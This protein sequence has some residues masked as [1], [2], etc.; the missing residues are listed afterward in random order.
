MVFM[1]KEKLSEEDTILL[2][3]NQ[4]ELLCKIG[5]LNEITRKIQRAI[6]MVDPSSLTFAR[7]F[8]MLP[9]P[10]KPVSN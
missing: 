7:M 9:Y 2:R 6:G 10:H 3:D 4:E 5:E 8:D 1:K